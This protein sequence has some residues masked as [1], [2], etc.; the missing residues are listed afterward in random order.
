M[1][2]LQWEKKMH[3]H[4][5]IR[6]KFDT[7]TERIKLNM[8]GR[9]QFIFYLDGKFV[10]DG[11]TRFH[12][13]NPQYTEY[14]FDMEQG[15]H[16]ITVIH[17][18]QDLITRICDNQ[19]PPFFMIEIYGE[20]GREIEPEIAYTNL[21]GFDEGGSIKINAILGFMEWRDT[22]FTPEKLFDI[23]FDDSSW[24]RMYS[25]ERLINVELDKT[26]PVRNLEIE[27]T[28]IGSGYL[29]EEFGYEKDFPQARFSLRRLRH[30][31]SPPQ[32]IWRRYDLGTVKLVRPCITINCP[33][34]ATV[35]FALCESLVEG[36]RVTPF[37]SLTT[38]Q[39][40]NM[41]HFTA[42]GGVET[43]MPITPLGGRYLEVHIVCKPS[44]VESIEILEE[45]AYWRTFF[46]EK[47]GEFE[48]ND[49]R[50][51][52]IWQMGVDTLR[53][54]TED[55]VTDCPVRE[56]G[57]WTGDSAVV[58]LRT[59]SVA[60]GDL[61]VIR[62]SLLQA[63]TLANEDGVIPA[64]F[65][66]QP[67]YFITY[68]LLWVAGL[69]DY[70]DYC[71]DD[72]LLREVYGP[73]VRFMDFME[74]SLDLNDG[75][76]KKNGVELN[77]GF[78]DWGY[79]VIPGRMVIPVIC[80]YYSSLNAYLE[81]AEVLGDNNKQL[82]IM[83]QMNNV[84]TLLENAKKTIGHDFHSYVMM[85]YTGMYNDEEKQPILEFVKK[86]ILDCFPNNPDAPRLYSPTIFLKQI[87][88]PFFM[89][90][91]LTA[92]MESGEDEYAIRQIKSCWGYMLDLGETTCLEV[93]DTRWSHCHQWS[94]CP[95]W[96][97]THYGLGLAKRFTKGI[98][99]FEFK[100]RPGRIK[101]AKGAIPLP[102]GSKVFVEWDDGKFKVLPEKNIT[103]HFENGE[104][105][106][107]KA[108]IE[109]TIDR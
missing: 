109:T 76:L 74:N 107:C 77:C 43:F 38:G 91:A 75:L 33:K 7:E 67:G 10:G 108:N 81:I 78:I 24:E 8:T 66:G 31:V 68:S 11:P 6:V 61:Q 27:M 46:D 50:L 85:L 23:D 51:N 15:K 25:K 106:E 20:D 65:P 71:G 12:Y 54:C 84:R 28:R 98:N 18:Y 83:R 104:T 21:G 69:R 3:A 45:K 60:Y 56:R 73:L 34:G 2:F 105:L 9:T 53:S 63:S 41:V 82:K 40:A 97:L 89:N 35:E 37:V 22:S 49:G 62:K 88:T 4:Y 94:G 87:I 80:M 58:G 92:L 70:Y 101:N 103:I 90:F 47:A 44:E 48:C 102:C 13:T 100:L 55:V 32:G 59:A 16:V 19:L 95:T 14:H 42:R 17:E 86:F 26:A 39:S 93:F 1:A 99:H 30:L 96:I 52:V 72:S 36:G 5:C 29:T 57:Q 64:L 79:E